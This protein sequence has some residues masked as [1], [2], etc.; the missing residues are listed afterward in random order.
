MTGPEHRRFF[1]KTIAVE[2]RGT[3]SQGVGELVFEAVDLSAGGTFLKAD[4][5]LE[6]GEHLALEFKVPGVP[7]VMRA[8]GRVAWVRRF[9]EKDQPGGMGVEFVRLTDDDRAVLSRYL[10]Q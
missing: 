8:D 1:R 4:L 2:F 7:R 9:P 3:D 5:L 6:L 10:G